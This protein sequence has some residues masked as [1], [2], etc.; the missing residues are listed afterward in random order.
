MRHV[1]SDEDRKHIVGQNLAQAQAQGQV[2]NGLA[3]SRHSR[4]AAT[5]PTRPQC[6]RPLR[7]PRGARRRGPRRQRRRGVW[8]H[9][10]R[11]VRRRPDRRRGGRRVRQLVGGARALRVRVPLRRGRRGGGAGP[12]G[13]ADPGHR[14]LVAPRDARARAVG[15]GRVRR[16]RDHPGSGTRAARA[17]HPRGAADRRRRHR[18]LRRRRAPGRRPEK[19]ADPRQVADAVVFL[20][21]QGPRAATHELQVTPLAET[22]VP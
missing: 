13:D 11:P 5:S 2:G 21:D 17:R 14:R 20:A 4:C 15:G 16:A 7:R 8:R 12:P 3:R 19:L 18:T 10:D 1:V 9:A 6:G 22:W